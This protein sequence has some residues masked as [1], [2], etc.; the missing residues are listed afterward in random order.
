[1]STSNRPRPNWTSF[2]RKELLD[3]TK[4]FDEHLELEFYELWH[5]EGRRA[6]MGA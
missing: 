2:T 6:R 3:K 1:M 4:F 5:H